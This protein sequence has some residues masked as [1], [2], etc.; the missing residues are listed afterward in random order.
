MA[1]P[2]SPQA[3]L[4]GSGLGVDLAARRLSLDQQRIEKERKLGW[5]CGGCMR[6]IG[7]GFKFTIFSVVEGKGAAD[8]IAAPS[9]YA[10]TRDD[11]DYAPRCSMDAAHVETTP[12]HVYLDERRGERIVGALDP[13]MEFGPHPDFPW[14]KDFSRGPDV[15]TEGA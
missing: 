4:I 3:A 2:G 11:C 1:K 15:P 9:T 14:S 5:R 12:E 13:A 8:M 6:R 10:C 7:H